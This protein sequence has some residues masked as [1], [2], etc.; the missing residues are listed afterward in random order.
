MEYFLIAPINAM[1]ARDL[2]ELIDEIPK[3]FKPPRKGIFR[4]QEQRRKFV[5]DCRE[6]HYEQTRVLREPNAQAGRSAKG[7]SMAGRKFGKSLITA[8]EVNAFLRTLPVL[9]GGQ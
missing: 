5:L 2:K 6:L 9:E 8:D 1:S 7:F 4:N 3:E